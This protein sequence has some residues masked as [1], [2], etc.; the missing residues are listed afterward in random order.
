M[1]TPAI[2]NFNTEELIEEIQRRTG[3]SCVFVRQRTNVQ[4]DK[5]LLGVCGNPTEVARLMLIGSDYILTKLDEEDYDDD[6]PDRRRH[7][8][9]PDGSGV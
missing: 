6:S 5:Y 4:K 2:R 9:T 3:A 1:V 8:D 7:P